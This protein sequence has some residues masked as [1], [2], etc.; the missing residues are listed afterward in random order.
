MRVLVACEVSGKVRDAFTARGHYADIAKIAVE[1]PVMH[2][3]AKQAIVNYRE[4]SQ[5]FQPWQFGHGET[6]RTCLW[7]KGLAP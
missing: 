7:L 4:P 5:T 1:N 6:K 2:K 3:H